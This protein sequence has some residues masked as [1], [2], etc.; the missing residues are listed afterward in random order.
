MD[1]YQDPIAEAADKPSLEVLMDEWRRASWQGLDGARINGLDDIRYSRWAGQTDDGKKHSEYR[2]SGEPAW[3]FEGASDVR[4]RLA[5]SVCNELSA[6]LLTAFSRADLRGDATEVNDLAASQTVTTLLKWVKEN[7]LS[8]ELAREAELGSQYAAQY[9]WTTFFVGWDQKISMRKQKISFDEM[10]MNSQNLPPDSLL[11]TLPDLVAN[12]EAEDQAATMFQGLLPIEK[13]D[14][15]E[16]VRGLR[17]NGVGEYEQEYV[18][19]NL[20]MVLALKPY[21]EIALPPE[22]VDLQSAR[23]IFRRCW[24]TEVELREK[25]LTAGWDKDWVDQVCKIGSWSASPNMVDYETA[26]TLVAYRTIDRKNLIE[27]VYAYYR[28]IDNDKPAIYYSVFSPT[29]AGT[30]PEVPQFAIHEL[31]D[32]AHGDYPFVEYRFERTKRAVVDSRGVPEIVTTDQDEMKA[33]HDSLRDRTA[34]ETL[35]PIKVVKRIGQPTKVGPGVP[36]PV[37][38]SDDYSFLE[39]P[40]RAPQTAFALIERVDANVANYFGLNH[41]AVNPVKAQMLQQVRVNNWLGSWQQVFK[42]MLALC[43]QYMAPQEIERI[44]GVPLPQNLTDIA[45]SFDV[46]VRFDVRELNPSYVTEKLASISKFV[47][48]LDAGGVVDRNRLVTMFLQAIAPEAARDLI[49]DQGQASEAMYRQVQSD[50]GLMMLGSE[51]LYTEND[52]AAKAKMQMVQDVMSKNPKAQA[53]LQQDPLFQAL[54]T[55]Y[56]KNLE[57][58]IMQSQNASIGRMGVA[59]IAPQLQQAQQQL[60]AG[61]EQM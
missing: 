11:R 30:D 35:P 23:V 38:R 20:P 7:K 39:P 47:V 12:P 31:L 17:E 51:A 10:L 60:T 54:F 24:H 16:L 52:P 1:Y 44:T 41:T 34:F 5:D 45:G 26:S 3:P 27:V 21:D 43:L 48:P 50:I 61:E 14:A 6:L 2:S 19:R 25:V 46:N 4:C 15:V 28:T 57:M 53:S 29:A 13:D 8:G 33:Q 55:N 56:T 58:S 22:T 37:T 32:Y 40:A 9:G 49:V 18:S 42:Q 59:P 36:L